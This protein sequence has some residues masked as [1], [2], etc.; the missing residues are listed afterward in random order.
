MKN[1]SAFSLATAVAAGA[2][3]AFADGMKNDAVPDL[4]R[5]MFNNPGAVVD[6]SMG[7]WPVPFVFDY[8]G[9]GDLDLFVIS[10]SVPFEGAWFFE[11]PTPKGARNPMPVFK[12]G[13]PGTLAARAKTEKCPPYRLPGD[14]PHFREDRGHGWQWADIDG[15]GRED[16]VCVVND[17]SEYGVPGPKCP[18]AYDANETWTNNQILAYVYWRRNTGGRGD[19]TKWGETQKLLFGGRA[20]MKPGPYGAPTV[21]F[22]D[23]D[24]D[25]DLD[26]V[27]TD[28]LSEFWYFA[29][30]GTKEKPAFAEGQRMI[31]SDGKMLMGDLCMMTAR[32]VD[33]DG[34]G[35]ADVI[36]SEEDGRV[37]FYRNTGR[38]DRGVPVFD[39]GRYFKQEARELKFHCIPTPCCAD[40]DGDGDWDIVC[41]DTAGYVGFIENL[42][43]PG[44]ERPKWA[45]PRLF[46]VRDPE[47]SAYRWT[48]GRHIRATCG[49]EN[50]PQGPAEQ[51]W[52]YTQVCVADWDGDGFLDIVANDVKGSVVW[53]RNPGK[54]GTTALFAARPIE[55]EW[56]GQQ[57]RLAWEW[58]KQPE[59]KSLRAP[60]R[61]TPMAYDWDGDGLVDLI[62]IDNKGY[63][64]LYRRARRNG[65]LVLLPPRRIFA[66]ANGDPLRL[67]FVERGGFGRRKIGVTDWNR[68]GRPDFIINAY[69]AKVWV[70][71]GE[72]NGMVRFA[73]TPPLAQRRLEGHPCAPSTADFD[74]DGWPDLVIG[75]E[76]GHF[77]YMRNPNSKKKK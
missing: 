66:N 13:I 38:L 50:S 45:P 19:Q 3:L 67:S 24:G 59:G 48:D 15:D 44:V 27:A 53:F 5:M 71:Q 46:T 42:S 4:E 63:L 8:D 28:F 20:E 37:A 25:G 12:A 47:K 10:G 56:E 22:H 57:P 49:I 69:N 33:W 73:E 60:W 68:D 51:K 54:K 29:N 43:G 70:N 23:W 26:I 2:C 52:G 11:N 75:G 40:W 30:E 58:R 39:K 77:Y 35:F 21:M 36:A 32:K 65:R 16:A 18:L 1:K 7:I 9:D 64:A 55:V 72:T 31:A 74:N 61:T 76:D 34:D 14:S 6:L 17:W 62:M 41:G